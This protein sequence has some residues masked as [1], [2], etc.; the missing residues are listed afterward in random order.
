[1]GRYRNICSREN[2]EVYCYDTYRDTRADALAD[3]CAQPANWERSSMYKQVNHLI[4]DVE[5]NCDS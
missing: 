1:M 2:I 4:N 3:V 5:L